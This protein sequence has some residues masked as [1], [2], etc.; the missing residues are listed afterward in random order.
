MISAILREMAKVAGDVEGRIG[1]KCP[2]LWCTSSAYRKA[3]IKHGE[4]R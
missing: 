4:V 2:L 3:W 1:I